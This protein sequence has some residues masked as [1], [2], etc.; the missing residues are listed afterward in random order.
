MKRIN[1][2]KKSESRTVQGQFNRAKSDGNKE[3]QE[4]Y[5]E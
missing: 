1:Q 3:E 4:G 5:D 2:V